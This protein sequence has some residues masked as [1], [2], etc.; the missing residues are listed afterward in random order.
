M[1]V[2]RDRVFAPISGVIAFLI[3]LLTV[4]M[5]ERRWS[6]LPATTTGL[7]VTI[8]MTLAE[9]AV[10]RQRLRRIRGRQHVAALGQSPAMLP[11]PEALG[12]LPSFRVPTK[13]IG[14]GQVEKRYDVTVTA[15]SV[16]SYREGFIVNLLIVR[17]GPVARRPEYLPAPELELVL[18][19]DRAGRYQFRGLGDGSGGRWRLAPR[20]TPELDRSAR[21]LRLEVR[22]IRWYRFD[23]V[24]KQ[25]TLVQ[26][27][28]GPWQFTIPLPPSTD[29][30]PP[31]LAS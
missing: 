4:R 29:D 27:Q 2:H 18:Q 19:D 6:A 22:E 26:T 10:R 5:T 20:F 25:R 3:S 28:P 31:T 8:A 12:T 17:D 13:V 15:L 7:A 9:P 23:M 14:S 16:E 24:S 1:N 21:E 30:A 11:R